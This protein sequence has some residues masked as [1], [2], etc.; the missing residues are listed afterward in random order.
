MI[1][2]Y[3]LIN[4]NAKGAAEYSVLNPDTNSLSAS[5]KSN[6]ALLVSATIEIRNKKNK[7]NNGKKLN[8]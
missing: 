4:H 7:G 1:L 3:S 6:G 8:I 2:P 5:G